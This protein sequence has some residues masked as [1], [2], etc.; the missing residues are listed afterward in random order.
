MRTQNGKPLPPSICQARSSQ[1][2]VHASVDNVLLHKR[3]NNPSVTAVPQLSS[4]E[5]FFLPSHDFDVLHCMPPQ[6][7]SI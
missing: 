6:H 4:V 5:H 7:T 3:N 2:V 1:D